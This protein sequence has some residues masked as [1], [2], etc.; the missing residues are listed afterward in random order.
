MPRKA[1]IAEFTAN[2]DLEFPASSEEDIIPWQ[3]FTRSF[4]SLDLPI[5]ADLLEKCGNNP[6]TLVDL[7]PYMIHNP[8][9]V[10]TT[11][12]LKKCVDIFR[13]MHLRHLVVLHP[14]TGEVKGIITRKDLFRFMDL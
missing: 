11:D 4:K 7:R 2:Y 13:M 8:Y 9:T 14:G 1:T 6:K 5:E 10:Q 12:Y 3:Y